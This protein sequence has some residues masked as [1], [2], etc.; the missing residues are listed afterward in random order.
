MSEKTIV[1]LGS[2]NMDLVVST[3]RAPDMGETVTGRTFR[4]VPGGKGANQALAAA[5]A[6]GTVRFLGAVGDDE[7]G[8]RIQ[9]LLSADGVDV[10]GMTASNEPTGTAHI[11]VDG[12]GGNS[13]IV[14]PGANGTVT[15]LTDEHRG[16]ISSAATLL[17]QLELPLK[18]VTEASAFARWAGVRTVLTPAPVIPLPEALLDNVDLLVANEHEAAVLAGHPGTGS[19]IDEAEAMART[20]AKRTKEVVVT[21]GD[22]GAMYA[23]GAGAPVHVP[24]F[25]VD[26]VDTTAAGDTF[27]GVLA[28]GLAEDLPAEVALRRASAAAALAVKRFGASTSMPTRR[29]IDKF[30]AANE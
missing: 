20:L 28:A 16:V 10:S 14:V 17:L 27:V 5:R 13:I 12:G 22:Q 9:R 4:T 15:T 3:E 7:F 6:G 8:H 2:A 24:A 26:A 23:S 11:T 30:L 21:L 1:V 18:L 29:E 19:A 25:E